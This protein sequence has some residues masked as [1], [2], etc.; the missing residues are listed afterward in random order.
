MC[1]KAWQGIC[2]KGSR[3]KVALHC[4]VQER[5][6]QCCN[7]QL[8]WEHVC[9]SLELQ[10]VYKAGAFLT[11][12]STRA[13]KLS[14]LR[15]QHDGKLWCTKSVSTCWLAIDVRK[16]QWPCNFL[17]DILL[18]HSQ[19]FIEPVWRLLFATLRHTR[20]ELQVYRNA[21]AWWR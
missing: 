16:A 14:Q 10:L 20:N 11:K 21:Q 3:A 9:R 15:R 1:E 19:N 7:R 8:L 5:E 18:F 2:T 17:G 6:C 4:C 12:A 13:S